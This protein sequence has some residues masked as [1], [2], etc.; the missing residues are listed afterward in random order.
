MGGGGAAN[1]G[2]AP[3]GYQ[4]SPLR[5]YGAC[6]FFRSELEKPA[7]SYPA[8]VARRRKKNA[9][10]SAFRT[11][12]PVAFFRAPFELPAPGRFDRLPARRII[13]AGA[14][15]L[16]G[17]ILEDSLGEEVKI[18][19]PDDH[20]VAADVGVPDVVDFLFDEGLMEGVGGQADSAVG[21]RRLPIQRSLSCLLTLSGS[22]MRVLMFWVLGA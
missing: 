13:H 19:P 15:G 5:G 10:C 22:G 8:A 4:K 3:H 20:V 11:L 1:H 6:P 9:G 2:L 14:S 17:F 12:H 16:G 21:C 7:H 18:L